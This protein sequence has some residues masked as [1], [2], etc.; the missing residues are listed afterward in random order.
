MTT[1]TG[2]VHQQISAAYRRMATAARYRPAAPSDGLGNITVPLSDLDLDE[3]AHHY[4]ERWWSE[5][6][7]FEFWIGCCDGPTRPATIYA[8]EAA[9]CM[10]AGSEAHPIAR[11]LLLLAL[12]DLDRVGKGRD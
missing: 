10:C 2:F 12:A 8:V 6:D 7:A 4:A 9:R 3:E 5:E 1:I 11:R